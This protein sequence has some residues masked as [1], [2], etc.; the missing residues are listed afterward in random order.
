[1]RAVPQDK[2]EWFGTPGHFFDAHNCRFHMTTRVGL[3]LISTVGEYYPKSDPNLPFPGENIG[4]DRK[5]ETAVFR[6]GR[7]CSSSRCH[8]CN[9]PVNDGCE[10]EMLP[11]N[12]AGDANRNHAALCKKWAR[13][14]KP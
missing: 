2:W 7:P 13:K 5:Y 11:A 6:A 4:Y 9:L 8:K 14:D 1:M 3:W 10:L 12:T